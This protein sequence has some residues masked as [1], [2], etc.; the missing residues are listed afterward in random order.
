[1]IKHILGVPPALERF[2]RLI[3]KLF[4]KLRFPGLV[5]VSLGIENSEEDVDTF[6]QVLGKIARLQK[7]AV[8]SDIKQQMKDFTMAATERVYTQI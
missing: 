7:T 3:Q 8:H 1:L 4:P 6:I 2:Q 5:R